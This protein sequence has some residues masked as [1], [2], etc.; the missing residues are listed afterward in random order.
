LNC[1]WKEKPA[2][3][4]KLS[5]MPADNENGWRRDVVGRWWKEI[6][7]PIIRWGG[8]IVDPGG[9][10]WKNGIGDRD[11][12]DAFPNTAWGRIDSNDVG[13]DEFCQSAKPWGPNL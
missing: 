7:P 13:I 9:Y 2:L 6:A 5:L 11:L 12:R 10:R 8:S 1:A 3:A 4:D